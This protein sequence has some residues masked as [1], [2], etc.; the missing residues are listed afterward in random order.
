MK[1]ALL[2]N[3][4]KKN[5]ILPIFF[6]K[7]KIK[8]ENVEFEIELI[9]GF[10]DEICIPVKVLINNTDALKAIISKKEKKISLNFISRNGQKFSQCLR[11]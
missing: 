5:L 4:Y 9:I 8:V 6:Y 10:C 2:L 7:K 11:T 3:G 1:M